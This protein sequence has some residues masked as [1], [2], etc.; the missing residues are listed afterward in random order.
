MKPISSGILGFLNKN[1][2]TEHRGLSYLMGADE[3][4]VSIANFIKHY[5]QLIDGPSAGSRVLGY[6]RGRQRLSCM[7][8]Q[9]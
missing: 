9:K 7:S 5:N 1:T 6:L 3:G 8:N 4:A 2:L